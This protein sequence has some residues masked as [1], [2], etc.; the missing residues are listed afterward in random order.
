MAT[1]NTWESWERRLNEA[2]D[3]V[4][5]AQDVLED[6]RELRDG[7]IVQAHEAGW[8]QAKIWKAAKISERRVGAILSRPP[9]EG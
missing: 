8:S 3:R 6:E 4:A 7:L 2:G 5:A 1:A 9:R